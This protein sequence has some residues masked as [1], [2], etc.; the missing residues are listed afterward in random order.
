MEADTRADIY[1]CHQ[2]VHVL[3][4]TS[5]LIFSIFHFDTLA[6]VCRRFTVSV[7]KYLFFKFI[8][9]FLKDDCNFQSMYRLQKNS[10]YFFFNL[11]LNIHKIF[12]T[13]IRNTWFQLRIF[14]MNIVFFL[15]I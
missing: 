1:V 8:F 9:T 5:T 6:I 13:S 15:F 10:Q 3:A 14:T 7:K 4:F 12:I 11:N 2:R